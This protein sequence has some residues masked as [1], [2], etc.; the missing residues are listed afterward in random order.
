MLY[1]GLSRFCFCYRSDAANV[2]RGSPDPAGVPDRRSPALPVGL[3][4]IGIFAIRAHSEGRRPAVGH[5]CGVGRP[6]H[7]RNVRDLR[8]KSGYPKKPSKTVSTATSHQPSQPLPSRT[9][10]RFD[11]LGQS[12]RHVAAIIPGR[13]RAAIIPLQ[14]RQEHIVR[15]PIQT[16]SPRVVAAIAR[17][18]PVSDLLI[19]GILMWGQV[20]DFGLPGDRVD[21]RQIGVQIGELGGVEMFQQMSDRAV[22]L[23]G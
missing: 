8:H 11:R 5:S 18:F 10:R 15:H 14:R 20:R 23:W 21:E 6:A 2:R 3:G 19:C 12:G 1:R 4:F 13:V 17:P 7:N 9:E 22:G 16:P